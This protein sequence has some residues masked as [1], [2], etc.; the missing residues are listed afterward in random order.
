MGFLFL[1]LLPLGQDQGGVSGDDV[2]DQKQEPEHT[3]ISCCSSDV[4]FLC[5]S[6]PWG[7]PWDTGRALRE[8]LG[9]GQE[10]CSCSPVHRTTPEMRCQEKRAPLERTQRKLTTA[11]VTGSVGTERREAPLLHAKENPWKTGWELPR[12]THY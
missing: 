2:T 11:R 8:S 9:E 5:L 10:C 4:P 7:T 6:V 3:Q 12:Y 1:P